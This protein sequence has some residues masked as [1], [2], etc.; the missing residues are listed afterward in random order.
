MVV[1]F[2]NCIFEVFSAVFTI[3]NIKM[4]SIKNQSVLNVILKKVGNGLLMS[5]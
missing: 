1:V 2:L 3:E 5:S 4:F